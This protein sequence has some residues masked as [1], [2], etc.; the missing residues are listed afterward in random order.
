MSIGPKDLKKDIQVSVVS[1]SR[2]CHS[3]DGVTVNVAVTIQVVVTVKVVF[4]VK[5]VSQSSWG[6]SE[7]GFIVNVV[8]Q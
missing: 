6:H 3:Q 4:T 7:S 1:Q 2:W 5:A 8:S